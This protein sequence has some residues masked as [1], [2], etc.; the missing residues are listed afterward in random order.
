MLVVM[1]RQNQQIGQKQLLKLSPQ[2]IQLLNFI[3]CNPL[4][5]E[6]KIR[7]ELDDNPIL[8]ANDS[9]ADLKPPT[10]SSPE[11]D[12]RI[13][14]ERGGFLEG[15]QQDDHTPDYHTVTERKSA[16]ES[17]FLTNL[18]AQNDFREQ[19]REQLT[20]QVLSERE[21]LVANYIVDSLDDDGYLRIPLEDL[22]DNLSFLHQILVSDDELQAQ[23]ETVQSLE[24]TGVGARDL[25]ECLLLQIEAKSNR[26]PHIHN[27]WRIVNAHL[28]D[29]ATR[30]YPAIVAALGITSAEVK[31]AIELITNL[32]PKPI[33]TD[34]HQLYKNQ[35]IIP[36]L[37]VEKIEDDTFKVALL[38]SNMELRLS[39]GMMAK[40][41]QLR[42]SKPAAPQQATVQ[43]MK[44]KLNSA[45]W[46]LDMIRLREN[47]M[48]LTMQAIVNLQPE[49]F[50]SGDPKRMRPM[51]LKDV[52]EQTGFDVSTIS[53]VTSSK[54]AQTDFGVVHL[55]S[56]FNQGM[57]KA[58]GNLVTNKEIMDCIEMIIAREDKQHPISDQEIVDKL[59]EQ[60]YLLARRTIAKY[61]EILHIPSAK[62]RKLV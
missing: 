20:A 43:Y 58:D 23:L 26:T 37:I 4:E 6:Q 34:E 41:D 45:V 54:Y 7:D 56:L 44:S 25:R 17:P 1:I 5:L 61:R 15:Y 19:L 62:M 32:N 39:P 51:G 29:L 55:K 31:E 52:A 42:A 40:L 28:N 12:T 27:A 13:E 48:L 36:E 46:F 38:N 35:N 22:A 49:Y 9:A 47:S 33:D 2:Q 11:N 14:D 10:E 53:R 30:N 57:A 16:E 8:E 21:L 18:V 60:G 50:E 59:A 24:P 3:Q